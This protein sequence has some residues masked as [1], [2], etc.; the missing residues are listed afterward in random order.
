MATAGGDWTDLDASGLP[1]VEQLGALARFTKGTLPGNMLSAL[2][3][4]RRAPRIV[5]AA[6]RASLRDRGWSPPPRPARRSYPAVYV[7]LAGPGDWPALAEVL[8]SLARYE[9]DAK[10]VVV[11]DATTDCRERRVRTAYPEVDVVRRHWPSLGPPRNFPPL[12]HGLRWALEAYDF[13][14]LGKLDTDALVTGGAPSRAAARFFERHPGIGM[15]GTYRLRGDGMAEDYGF[16]AF[17]L[18]QTRRWSPTARRLLRRAEAGGYDGAKVHGG[19]YYVSRPALEAV[20]RDCWL[21]W[22]TPWWT[23]LSE[24]FWLSVMVLA[25]G[26]RLGSLGGP[27][28]P[29]L[30]A[31]KHLPLPKEQVLAEGKLAV[32]SVRRGH[33]GESEAE[34]RAFFRQARTPAESSSPPENAPPGR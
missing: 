29:L 32:H 21:R 19:V 14:V 26:F 11:D 17:V 27:G 5:A 10:A 8:D 6:V 12:A 31:S 23:Q 28:E 20:L 2:W 34:L 1:P 7:I 18:R 13:E 30:V 24:D 4:R 33:G 25:G 22:R 15:A 16:D 9:P 3:R